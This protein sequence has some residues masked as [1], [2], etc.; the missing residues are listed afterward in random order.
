MATVPA[1]A[2]Q[3]LAATFRGELLVAGD[4]GYDLARAVWNAMIDRRPALI[5]RCTGVADVVA[6]V[7]FA[8][9]TDL[10]VAVRGGGH[11][12]AGNAVCDDGIVVDLSPMRG[13]LVDP[14]KRTA[15]AQGGVTWGLFDRETQAFGLA[16]TGGLVSTTGIAGLT[17]G[18]GLGWL[19]RKHGTTCDNLVSADVV[20]AS[21]D[22][23]HASSTENDD[24]FWGLRG[25]GGN[26]GVVTSFEYTLHP[27][28][29]QVLAGAVFHLG[30]SAAKVL[31]F[32][33]DFVAEAPDQLT[34]IAV[35]LT[36][37][38]APFLPP[39]VHGRLLVALAACYAGD[40]DEGEQALRPLRDHGRPVADV[41]APMPYA[42]LQSMFDSSYP[43]GLR[44]Y[45]KSNY[46]NELSDGA[47]D[48]AVEYA[49]TMTSPLSS[50]YFEHL[51]G[52]IDRVDEDATAFGHRDLVFDW[53]TI[54]AWADTAE[55][56]E[57]IAW[58]R[59]FADAMRPFSPD[60][61][62]VNNLGA[63]GEARV[64]AA[65]TPER[66][67]RLVALKDAY[68]PGNLFR[69]NQNIRPSLIH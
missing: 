63:E 62:Y 19:A 21:G 59:E 1:S 49:H 41:I 51:G 30:D 33:R 52:A 29:P 55:T 20:N 48:V 7:N 68:D 17:L 2:S 50:F 26:F 9:D 47:I 69:L 64:R 34:V 44:Y 3:E 46:L 57:H 32:F 54:A 14:R 27:V 53:T 24:L 6:A 42:A 66:Y 67:A 37:P 22:V 58:T 60:A 8:R 40:L 15:R 11:N 31:R 45:W 36:A 56:N 13:V 38:E 28:G 39:E 35:V 10:L 16:T 43:H 5:A 18:G 25:G 23:V 4:D 12:V 65:Y 61:V